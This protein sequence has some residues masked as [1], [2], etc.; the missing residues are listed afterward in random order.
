MVC[1][2]V[3]WHVEVRRV[4]SGY[5]VCRGAVWCVVVRYDGWCHSCVV[6]CYRMM[7][8]AVSC[9]TVLVCDMVW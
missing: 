8:D 7:C 5:V 2:V 1:C 3:L 4:V 6:V 9:Y